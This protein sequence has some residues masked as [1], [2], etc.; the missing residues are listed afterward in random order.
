VL[1]PA[2]PDVDPGAL[3]ALVDHCAAIIVTGGGDVSPDRYR[4]SAVEFP[5]R[6]MDVDP[7]RDDTEVAVVRRAHDQGKRILGVCRGIQLLAVT[8]GGTLIPDLVAA[9]HD[10]HWEEER[11]YEPVHA[12]RA[13]PGSV[14]AAVL[15]DVELVNSIHHQAVAD[16]GQVLRAT[17]WSA[18]GVIE[19][20][21]A[22]G[23]LGLQWHPE[24]LSDTDARHL[25]PFAWVVGR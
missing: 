24:R 12:V 17:A 16:P 5:D 6:L 8:N 25:A 19:A 21:E 10:G 1:V 7:W 3:A 13:E 20:I 23:L 22:P 11:Q 15:G 4:D 18:D 14:A 9:G 2:G